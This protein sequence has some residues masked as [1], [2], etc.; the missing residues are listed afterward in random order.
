MLKLV[1]IFLYPPRQ[2][3]MTDDDDMKD[4]HL[5]FFSMVWWSPRQADGYP[6]I[7]A[8]FFLC[9]DYSIAQFYKN[10]LMI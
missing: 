4:L 7:P 6:E 10:A 5:D 3:T 9:D 8:Q 1:V 2:A